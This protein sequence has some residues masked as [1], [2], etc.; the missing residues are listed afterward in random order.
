MQWGDEGK[1]KIVDRLAPQ[2]AAVVRYNG[3][4]NAGHSV[5]VGDQRYALHLVPCGVLAEGTLAIIANGVVLDPVKLE[6]ELSELEARG[7]DISSVMISSRAHVVM[8]YHKA[9]DEAREAALVGM[10]D[11]RAIGTTKRGIGPCYAEKSHRSGAVRAGDLVRPEVLRDRIATSLATT[12][13]PGD[14]DEIAREYAAIG[15][16]LAPRIV[17]T[18]YLLHDIL[19]RGDRVLFEGGNAT[20]LDVDHGT[21]PHVTASN[22]S[23]LGIPAGSGVPGTRLDR[24][25]GIMKAYTTRVG[26]GPMPTELHDEIGARIRE[27]GR[28]FGTTTGRPRRCGWL[29][30]VAARY[31]AMVN[32]ATEVVMTML[33]VLAGLEEIKVCTAYRV[34]RETTDRFLPDTELLAAAEPVYETLPGFEQD[35]TG[36][37]SRTDLPSEARAYI[38]FV[39]SSIGVRIAEVSVGPEREQVLS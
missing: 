27:L 4:A 34:D 21:F 22:C 23:A 13:R 24:V 6:T 3:G 15:E 38:D 37:R 29:D 20:L 31:S 30:V 35:V 32:G 8:P 10:G 25:I 18:T 19:N 36:C 16:R 39:E 26:E 5:V 11:G 14:A 1:G 33:D 28:E 17:D 7:V 12:G 2:F 9:E